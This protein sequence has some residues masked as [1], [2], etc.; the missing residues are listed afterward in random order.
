VRRGRERVDDNWR[1]LSLELVQ[2]ADPRTRYPIFEVEYLRII[3][4]TNF[5]IASASSGDEF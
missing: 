3:S 4:A 1:L 5:A 2:R